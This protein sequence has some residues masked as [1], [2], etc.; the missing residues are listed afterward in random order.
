M[1]TYL[2]IL[3]FLVSRQGA[4]FKPTALFVPGRRLAISVHGTW[5]PGHHAD[6]SVGAQG[7][8]TVTLTPTEVSNGP[9]SAFKVEAVATVDPSASASSSGEDA[10]ETIAVSWAMPPPPPPPPP[11]SP[12]PAGG[13]KKKPVLLNFKWNFDA[14]GLIQRTVNFAAFTAPCLPIGA[15]RRLS[16]GPAETNLALLALSAIPLGDVSP[17]KKKFALSG[18]DPNTTLKGTYRLHSVDGDKAT[19]EVD[20]DVGGDRK[21]H[22]TGHLHAT[23]DFSIKDGLLKH[24]AVEGTRLTGVTAPNFQATFDVNGA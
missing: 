4:T 21:T 2:P 20:L 18:G 5:D 12:P 10:P 6:V 1:A 7:S 17:A 16:D 9:K 14:S 23:Y 22:P 15:I 8:D 24:G 11:A 3:L 19:I 13:K